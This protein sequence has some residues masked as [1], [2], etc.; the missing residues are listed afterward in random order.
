MVDE[1]ETVF[2]DPVPEVLDGVDQRTPVPAVEVPLDDDQTLDMEPDEVT[3][4][5]ADHG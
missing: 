4:G 1:P 2:D 3:G 5:E